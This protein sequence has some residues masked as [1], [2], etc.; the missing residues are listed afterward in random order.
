MENI[1]NHRKHKKNNKEKPI[2]HI[3]QVDNYIEKC[4]DNNHASFVIFP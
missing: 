4:I 2:K 1:E 3:E